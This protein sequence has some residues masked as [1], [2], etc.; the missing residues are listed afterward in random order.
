L[1][2]RVKRTVQIL[3]QLTDSDSP[4]RIALSFAIGV[5]IAFNPL[6]GLHTA[7]ALAIAYRLRLSRSAMLVGAYVNNPW[8]IAP[9]YTAGTVLGCYLLGASSVEAGE[10]DWSLHGW[11]F[12]HALIQGLRPYVWPFVV[13]NTV[14]GIVGGV[15]AYFALRS[16]LE[17]RRQAAPQA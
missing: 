10:I 2:A 7:L 5:W 14:L 12:Y 16:I 9:L 3:L 6:L 1:S 15:A 13:G 4:H 8:T 11:A 17:R